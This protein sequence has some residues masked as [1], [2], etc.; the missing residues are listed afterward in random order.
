MAFLEFFYEYC[1]EKS[2]ICTKFSTSFVVTK[3]IKIGFL[4]AAPVKN[5]HKMHYHREFAC[6]R[7]ITLANPQRKIDRSLGYKYLS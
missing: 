5:W 6:E 3:N 7:D 1:K 2:D 4:S